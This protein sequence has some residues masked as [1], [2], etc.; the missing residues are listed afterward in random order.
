MLALYDLPWLQ[1]SSRGP[2]SKIPFFKNGIMFVFI[3]GM[4]KWSLNESLTVLKD[5]V[6]LPFGFWL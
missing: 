4:G 6:E 3:S 2:N 5:T 1:H